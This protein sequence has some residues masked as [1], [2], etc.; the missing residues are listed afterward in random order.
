MN[1]PERAAQLLSLEGK[2]AM[3]TGAA[4]GIGRGIALA[5]AGMGSAVAVLDI[6]EQGGIETV[7][8][9]SEQGDRAVFIRCDVRSSHD[10]AE[11]A[12]RTVERFGKINVLCN[13]AG[14]VIRKTVVELHL[15]II[16]WHHDEALI[17]R[18]RQIT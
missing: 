12:T 10:C 7:S 3:V 17:P 13:N 11:A 4:S 2:V 1:I 8:K 14:I 16:N 6:D 5:L 18:E 15:G 9:I